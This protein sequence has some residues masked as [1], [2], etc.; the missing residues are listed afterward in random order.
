MPTYDYYCKA[1]N[2]TVE[3][4]HTMNVTL[5][6]WGEVCYVAQIPLG[7]TDPLAPVRK[8]ISAPA[9]AVSIGNSTL[10]EKG[11][12]KLVKRDKGV[13]ENV[14]ALDHEKRYMTAGDVSSIPDFKKKI[15]D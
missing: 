12:T 11:F 2:R 8:V 10:R 4:V 7:E 6:T 13:Y 14:T 9:I 3:V 5:G 1:N 15:E